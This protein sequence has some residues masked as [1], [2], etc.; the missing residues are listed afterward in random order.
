MGAAKLIGNAAH[1]FPG[2]LK[3]AVVPLL[4]NTENSGTVV[5]WSAATALAGIIQLNSPLNQELIEL[6]HGILKWDQ[7]K[8]IR[9][10]YEKALKKA[11]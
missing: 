6:T 10:I 11:K 4:N 9:K 7:D 8:A 2:L 3:K 1:L 5:R